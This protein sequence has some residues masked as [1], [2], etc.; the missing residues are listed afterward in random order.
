MGGGRREVGK[1]DEEGMREEGDGRREAGGGQ[2][3]GGRW[4]SY[5][6]LL[7]RARHVC[8]WEQLQH[9]PR[10]PALFRLSNKQFSGSSH[11]RVSQFLTSGSQ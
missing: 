6:P 7:A 1:R 4:E 5:S 8:P 11:S 10:S 2:K 9:Q 3:G